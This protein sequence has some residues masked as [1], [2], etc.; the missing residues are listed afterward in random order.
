MSETVY[1]KGKLKKVKRLDGESLEEQCERIFGENETAEYYYDS[2]IEAL[3]EERENFL[4]L[5]N[6]LFEVERKYVNTDD[7]I[8]KM[9]M[10]GHGEFEFEVKYYNGGCFFE[11]AIE[12]AY[13]YFKGGVNE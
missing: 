9:K 12:K 4:V 1:Y 7:D 6:I 13:N 11:E 8:F 10:N 3:T 5:E 2:Y